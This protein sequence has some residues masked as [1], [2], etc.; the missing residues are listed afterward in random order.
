MTIHELLAKIPAEKIWVQ[1]IFDGDFDVQHT[2]SGEK[3]T[4]YTNSSNVNPNSVVNNSNKV[5]LILWIDRKDFPD[6]DRLKRK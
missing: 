5:G 4:F 6:A 3:I 2:K 1:N